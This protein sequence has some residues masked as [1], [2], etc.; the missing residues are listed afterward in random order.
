[1]ISIS[2]DHPDLIDFIKVKTQNGAVTKANISVRVTDE[3]M[4]AV[5]QNLPWEMRFER[6]E[7][8]ELITSEYPAKEIYHMLCEANWNWAEPGLLFWDN[9]CNYNL[10]DNN[11]YFEYAGTNP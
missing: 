7:T 9:I 10:L 3:F 11:P 1:M 4:N 6:P 2:C 5:E 8:G